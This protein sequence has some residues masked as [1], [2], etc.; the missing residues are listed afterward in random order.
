MSG[1][2]SP[3]IRGA[4]LPGPEF[5]RGNP[6]KREVV[7]EPAVSLVKDRLLSCMPSRVAREADDNAVD[8]A[9]RFWDCLAIGP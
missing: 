7:P 8:L 5:R 1:L 3:R 6:E 2:G 9:N 4:I